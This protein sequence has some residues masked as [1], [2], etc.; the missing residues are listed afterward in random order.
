MNVN[1]NKSEYHTIKK[2]CKELLYVLNPLF[3]RKAKK[4]NLKWN[5]QMIK[6]IS[7]SKEHILDCYDVDED[8]IDLFR[9]LNE[10]L[11]ELIKTYDKE[12][13]EFPHEIRKFMRKLNVKIELYEK[14]EGSK[15]SK[16]PIQ[17]PE[18]N[19][20]KEVYASK[21]IKTKNKQPLSPPFYYGKQLFTP[22]RNLRIIYH[23]FV[24]SD[25]ESMEI[26]E[27]ESYMGEEI[28][29]KRLVLPDDMEY[30][31]PDYDG[32]VCEVTFVNFDEEILLSYNRGELEDI[33][34]IMNQKITDDFENS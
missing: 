16:K 34:G 14:D 28:L 30:L 17:E 27:K 15:K 6:K 26:P 25:R 22:H 24:N 3:I 9:T 10:S 2:S 13:V 11:Y 20:E 33:I 12:G 29:I 23:N 7:D 18:P 21:L 31:F 5:K 19:S 8:N 4:F 32:K 1:K